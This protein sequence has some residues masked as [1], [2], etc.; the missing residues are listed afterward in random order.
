MG[1]KRVALP[2]VKDALF[3]YFCL[4]EKK[5]VIITQHEES[6]RELM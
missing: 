6:L 4:D 2:E 3:R 1:M 5:E